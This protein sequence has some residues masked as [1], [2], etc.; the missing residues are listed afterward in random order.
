[1]PARQSVAIDLLPASAIQCIRTIEQRTEHLDKLVLTVALSY[2]GRA[3]I[4]EAVKAI[5]TDCLAGTLT[6][7][8]PLTLNNYRKRIRWTAFL[9][10]LPR[11]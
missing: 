2:G 1:M 9:T 7:S 4:V 10:D 5:A 3:E 8:R 11:C 6:P